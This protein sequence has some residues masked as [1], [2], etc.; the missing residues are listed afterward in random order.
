MEKKD[1][2]NDNGAVTYK[3]LFLGAMGIAYFR[4]IRINEKPG[5]HASLY[6][7]AVLDSEM[8]EN[9]FHEIRDNVSLVYRKDGKDHVLFYGVLDRIAMDKDGDEHVVIMEAWDGT[10]QMDV[11]RR[12]RIFQNPQMGVRQLIGQVMSTYAG[13]DYM[14]HIPDTPIGQL[15]VQYEETDWE[16]LKRFLS[17]YKEN[18]YPDPAFPDIRFEAGLSPK[19]EDRDWNRLP[20]KLSQDFIQLEAMKENGL[21]EVTKSQNT[22]YE[23][24]T[25]DIASIGSQIIYKGTSWYIE[26]AVR[27]LEDGLLKNRYR[28]RQK[29]SLKILPYYN[30]KITGISIDGVIAAVKRNQVQVN[31]D[32]EAGNGEKYWFPFSTVAASSDGSGWYCMPEN[33]ESVRVY[34]PVD[35]E[36]EAYVVTNVKGHEPQAGNSSDSMGN[37]NHRNIQTAQ[38]NQVQMTEE[39]VLIAAGKSQGSILLKKNGEV[40]LNALKD[41][42]VLAAESLNITAKKDLTIKSQTAIQVSCQSGADIEVK[43]GTVGLHGDEIHEN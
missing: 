17:K 28:L 40:I 16:F 31:M 2:P 39:G 42:T 11:E 41:I 26:S 4:R 9:D 5:E 34:F 24:E 13:S 12:K 38:G 30:G 23:V 10:R 8:D 20:Y 33:G 27:R 18:L 36:K 25:Y 22:V 7:E 14:I 3:D 29:E 32:I 19:P 15:V 6:V 37:P 1:D 21:G 35:D 43:K